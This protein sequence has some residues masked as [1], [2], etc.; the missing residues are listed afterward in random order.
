MDHNTQ[1]NTHILT[2]NELAENID[3]VR[4]RLILG[5]TSTTTDRFASGEA[6]IEPLNRIEYI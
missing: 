5:G 2:N 1:H 4:D 3:C 6:Q